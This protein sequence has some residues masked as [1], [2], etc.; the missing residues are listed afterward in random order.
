MPR[1]RGKDKNPKR[2]SPGTQPAPD[3]TEFH[4]RK[5]MRE[6]RSKEEKQRQRDP[7]AIA[8]STIKSK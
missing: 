8:R 6:P 2:H 5:V 4:H 3:E 1:R 7:D